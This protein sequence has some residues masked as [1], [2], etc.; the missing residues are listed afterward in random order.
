VT[1]P[2]Y[3]A[4]T[5]SLGVAMICALAIAL[6]GCGGSDDSTSTPTDAAAQDSTGTTPT[7]DRGNTHGDSD[8]SGSDGSSKPAADDSTSGTPVTPL[9]VSGGGSDQFRVKGGGGDN[10]VQE[11]GDEG[12]EDQLSEAAEIV[13]DFYALRATGDWAG[14]CELLSQSLRDRLE[15]LAKSTPDV[16]DT[17]CA[18]FL[19]DMTADLPPAEWRQI[20]TVDAGSLRYEGEQAFLIY[21]GPE[22]TVY[23]MPMIGEDDTWKINALTSAALPGA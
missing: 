17:R 5:T 22:R 16:E 4:K 1:V 6:G 9:K 20:T 8:G 7:A 13:H 19:A 2:R 12:D 18:P 11:F 10:S 3:P 21:Y 15:E 14:A 23:A